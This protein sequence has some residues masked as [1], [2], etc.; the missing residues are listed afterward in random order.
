MK[1]TNENKL[2]NMKIGDV[3]ILK[4][5]Y[6]ID[7]YTETYSVKVVRVPGYWIFDGVLVPTP[8]SF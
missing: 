2:R 3:L 1:E 8:V 5:S 7:D 6:E 4:T